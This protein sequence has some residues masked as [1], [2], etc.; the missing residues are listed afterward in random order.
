SEGMPPLV[1]AFAKSNVTMKADQL[2]SGGVAAVRVEG[3]VRINDVTFAGAK[4]RKFGP[5]NYAVWALP[6]AKVE[7]TNCKFDNW[8]HAFYG[9]ACQL[10]AVEN[11]VRRF[12]A[13]AFVVKDASAQL[14]V[15]RNKVFRGDSQAQVLRVSGATKFPVVEAGNE[16]LPAAEEKSLEEEIRDGGAEVVE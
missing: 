9:E 13:A 15:T 8:R 11:E 1:M 12:H 14:D 2:R 7:L 4:L 10:S 16:I 6:G 5:P 3:N